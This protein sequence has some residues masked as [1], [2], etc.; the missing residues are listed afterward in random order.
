[1]QRNDERSIKEF[2]T[3]FLLRL[4]TAQYGTGQEGPRTD[5]DRPTEAD[6]PTETEHVDG[7]TDE[8]RK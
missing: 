7:E 2:L 5:T 4:F 3:V 1:M 6:R 8:K